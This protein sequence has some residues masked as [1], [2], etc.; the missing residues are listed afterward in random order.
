MRKSRDLSAAEK[1][2]ASNHRVPILAAGLS[3]RDVTVTFIKQDGTPRVL[4]GHIESLSGEG[5]KEI[6]TLDTAEG[7]RSANLSRIVGVDVL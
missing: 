2:N 5:D 7:F 6:V 1:Q 4:T 3:G